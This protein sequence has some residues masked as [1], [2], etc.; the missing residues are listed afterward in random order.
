MDAA[1]APAERGDVGEPEAAVGPVHLGKCD[2]CRAAQELDHLEASKLGLVC[3]GCLSRSRR[4]VRAAW[5]MA[6]SACAA[7]TLAATLRSL[8]QRQGRLTRDAPTWAVSVI[9]AGL[10]VACAWYFW[11]RRDQVQR[12]AVT[13][14]VLA[15]ASSLSFVL[16][17]VGL[18]GDLAMYLFVPPAIV[19]WYALRRAQLGS[20]HPPR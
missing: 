18:A 1:S 14:T 5:A 9:T 13:H 4:F 7:G 20:F 10:A 6:V 11:T 19:A 17:V 3:S 8:G 12:S 16:A 2:L 15:I